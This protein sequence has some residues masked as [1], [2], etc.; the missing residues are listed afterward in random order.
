ME[1][2]IRGK[3]IAYEMKGKGSPIL[4][5]HGWGGS[6]LSVAKLAAIL[7]KKYNT[8]ILDLPGFGHSDI[9]NRDWGVAEYAELLIEFIHALKLKNLT[10]FGH[11]FGGA[12]GIYIA[13]KQP[14]LIRKLILCAPS[15][16]RPSRKVSRIQFLNRLIPARFKL[17]LYRIFFPGSDISKFPALEHNFRKIVTQD[18]TSY[19]HKIKA[20]TLILWGDKDSYVP[21]SYAYELKKNIKY[22]IMKIFNGH[23]HSIPL[24]YPELI[25]K[26]VEKFIGK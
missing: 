24:K 12:L 9:P 17:T 16:K 15:Y 1:I 26:E 22:S 11:S 5:V 4:L 10:Y 20:P 25:A 13:A 7:S 2:K 21:V 19:L 8:I 18:L 14:Q 6:S 3:T 23:F